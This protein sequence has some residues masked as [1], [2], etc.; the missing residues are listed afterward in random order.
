MLSRY[1]LRHTTA[2]LL[3]KFIGRNNN[4]EWYWALGVLYTEARAAANRVEF[5]LLAG[6]AQPATPACA[7][8]ARTWASYLKQALHRH[9]ASPEDLAVARLSVTFGL[10]AV[11]KRPGY[12]EYGD[13]F[14]CTLH[15]ASHDGRACVRER[16]EH[17]VPHEEFGSPWHR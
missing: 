9:A 5:D 4:Y 3:D 13:P 17:C 7:S 11:P 2:G 1:K 8:L 14:L 16:T 12:I 6:T 10:P 15:L